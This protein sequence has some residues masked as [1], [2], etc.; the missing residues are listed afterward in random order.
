MSNL[1]PNKHDASM[2]VACI[3]V[4]HRIGK[5]KDFGT[6]K[7]FRPTW[8]YD[9]CVEK[10]FWWCLAARRETKNRQFSQAEVELAG[11]VRTRQNNLAQAAKIVAE[12]SLAKINVATSAANNYALTFSTNF[13][14]VKTEQQKTKWQNKNKASMRWD[15]NINIWPRVPWLTYCGLI[16]P[17][18]ATWRRLPVK[19]CETYWLESKQSLVLLS[20]HSNA[21]DATTKTETKHFKF[22]RSDFLFTIVK[23]LIPLVFS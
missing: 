7:F 23:L 10:W 18:F 21:S 17:F 13:P 6:I 8:Y 12:F 22:K 19:L 2:F 5:G 16:S 15:I 3:S 11:A 14:S 1:C 9:Q 4:S 20:H